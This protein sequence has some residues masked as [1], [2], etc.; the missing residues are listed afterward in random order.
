MENENSDV[1]V[2]DEGTEECL[3][4]LV[5]CCKTGVASAKVS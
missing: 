3:E 2:L 4:N 1:M 5:K